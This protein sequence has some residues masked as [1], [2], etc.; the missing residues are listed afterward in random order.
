MAGRALTPMGVIVKWIL[1]PA[2]MIA[3]GFFL[4]GAK[5]GNIIPGIGGAMPPQDQ[6]ESVADRKATGYSAPDVDVVRDR[7][8]DPPEVQ[9]TSRRKSL[10]R[11]KSHPLPT[12]S[13]AAQSIRRETH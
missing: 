10:R 6:P 4:I 3:I 7:K 13:Q 11:R 5:V 8:M 2:G 12:T 9:V 1:I